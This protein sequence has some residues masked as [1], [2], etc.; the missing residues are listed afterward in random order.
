M[1]HRLRHNA[2]AI[3]TGRWEDTEGWLHRWLLGGQ[4]PPTEP[5]AAPMGIK[6]SAVRRREQRDG[7]IAAALNPT[8][9]DLKRNF[10]RNHP[11]LPPREPPN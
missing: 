4:A 3:A 1:L 9:E 8:D 11:P 10:G 2:W 6:R 7:V 5:R